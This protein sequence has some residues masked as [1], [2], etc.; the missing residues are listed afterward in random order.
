[1]REIGKA[2]VWLVS[3]LSSVTG[4]VAIPPP[5]IF[6]N[7]GTPVMTFDNAPPVQQFATMNPGGANTSITNF[8]GLDTAAKTNMATLFT[9]ALPNLTGNPAADNNVTVWSSGGFLQTRPTGVAY[10]ALLATLSNATASAIS[11]FGI[12]YDF[13]VF[14]T[15]APGSEQIPGTLVYYST[16]GTSGSWVQ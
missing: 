15:N 7:T 12:R 2:A 9:T 3:L 8:T 6:G 5:I 16:D 1:M 14:A 4:S 11:S 10:N 13:T